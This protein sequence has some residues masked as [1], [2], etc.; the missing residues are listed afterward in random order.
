MWSGRSSGRWAADND[1]HLSATSFLSH[2]GTSPICL[3]KPMAHWREEYLAALTV[4]DHREKAN[5]ALYDACP[6]WSNDL[7]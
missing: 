1:S 7:G 3:G 5:V 4:R 2:L 6:F